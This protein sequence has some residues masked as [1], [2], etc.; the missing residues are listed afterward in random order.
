MFKQADVVDARV[1]EEMRVTFKCNPDRS[2]AF[3]S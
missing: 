3:H 2:H 1:E